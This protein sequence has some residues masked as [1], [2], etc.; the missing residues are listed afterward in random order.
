MKKHI[1]QE[2]QHKKN[3]HAVQTE[4]SEQDGEFLEYEGDLWYE[5]PGYEEIGP[6]FMSIVSSDDLWMYISS[7]GGLTA[8][9]KNADSSLFPYYT[10]DK[11]GENYTNTGPQTIFRIKQEI[12]E[13]ARVAANGNSL[14]AETETGSNAAVNQDEETI[15]WKPFALFYESEAVISRRIRKNVTGNKIMFSEKHSA[16]G[17]EFSYMWTSS[18]AWGWV[19]KAKLRNT[20]GNSFRVDILDGLRNILPSCINSDMQNRMSNLINAYKL[21]ELF[22][23]GIAGFG[24]S[25]RISDKAEAS[26]CLKVTTAWQFGLEAQGYLLS[27]EQVPLFEQGGD[28]ASENRA[29]GKRGAFYVKA[30][31]EIPKEQEVSWMMVL[32]VEQD[33]KSVVTLQKY[34]AHRKSE[35][36]ML[37]EKDIAEA[38]LELMK[39]VGA[40]DGLER[41]GDRMANVHHY[42]NTLFNVMR[43]GVF[44][45]GYMIQTED[46]LDYLYEQNKAEYRKLRM[47]LSSLPKRLSWKELETYLLHENTS[48]KSELS[49]I[50]QSYLPLAFSRRHGDPSRPWNKFS[51]KLRNNDGR[52]RYIYEGNWR[53][54]FQNWE[55]LAY[56]FP[57]YTANM[58][59]VCANGITIDGYNP[60]RV[61]R[62]GFEWEKPDPDDP[63]SNIGYWGDHQIIYLLKL[64]ESVY[65]TNPDTFLD[66][67]TDQRFTFIDVPYKIKSFDK[68]LENPYET[69]IFDEAKDALLE[70]RKEELGYDGLLLTEHDG[71]IYTVTLMEKL[72]LIL[73]VKTTNFIPG[74]GIWMNTQRPEWNDANNALT[75]RGL[76]MVT[77]YYMIREIQFLKN[78]IEQLL[79][80]ERQDTTEIHVDASLFSLFIEIMEILEDFQWALK[81]EFTQS[82]RWDFL[83]R[84]GKAGSKYRERAY[85]EVSRKERRVLSFSEIK[86]YL[87]DLAEYLKKSG[88]QGR[89]AD[90]MF[91]AYTILSY[92]QKNGTAD[93]KPLQ[94][95]LEGQVAILS[96]GLLSA[97]ETVELL[98]TLKE[99]PLYRKDQHS[100]I[101]YPRTQVKG[102]LERNC[103]PKE[104]LHDTSIIHK[105][106]DNGDNS[107]FTKDAAGNYHFASKIM[108]TGS[109]A[110]ILEKM[111]NSPHVADLS[112]EEKD[113]VF[114]VF[115]EVFQHTAFTGRSG[116]MFA[117][118]GVGS[119]YW[120]M[121]SK[122][123]LAV[124][125]N[126]IKAYREGASPK[127]VSLLADAYYDIQY[128]LGYRKSA[129]KYGAFPMD[130]YS[131]T[132][133]RGGARQP[134]MTGQVKEEV[135]TRMGEKGL[136]FKDGCIVIDP[137]FMQKSE[138]VQESAVFTYFDVHQRK[139]EV[140]LNKGDFAYTCCQTLIVY[141]FTQSDQ[142]SLNIFY[143][144]GET[145]SAEYAADDPIILSP[146]DSEHVRWRDGLIKGIEITAAEKMVIFDRYELS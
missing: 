39:I 26:E 65:A 11:I 79:H 102:F 89:R 128:G 98:Q 7:T 36:A 73:L 142:K 68:I 61:V 108:N 32:E 110:D 97:E 146:E 138:L 19:R 24:M 49:R 112:A 22:P 15:I 107:L 74:G 132:V 82:A 72:L 48:V 140:R 81:D 75:G 59:T 60:Y 12:G 21:N 103:I 124:Q 4:I 90:G 47:R 134:G 83:N 46:F 117:Y 96:S 80:R 56:S 25:T 9:R 17:L 44:I 77:L 88:L 37:V 58:L 145:Y 52:M 35:T 121:V 64:M 63:W 40:A 135:L 85:A 127:T 122:L 69:I 13:D 93:I 28:L 10:H 87:F 95:M 38:E 20:G 3:V 14:S 106:I 27:E 131:H 92:N 78:I 8:G 30:S 29:E 54:I 126:L 136:S 51:I 70:K 76:S 1:Q 113:F 139:Q 143:A 91:H 116:R 133:W 55:P 57:Q 119:I 84:M 137:F 33:H 67:L 111:E 18:P 94:V 43:G 129:G 105:L 125:E 45:D 5:I 109:V 50:M 100:Y 118:E 115:E 23:A 66:M 42:S 31:L 71:S 41:T 62:N 99:S 34:L 16:L 6:F 130:P 53:D 2:T 144:D 123:L 104:K 120:H 141:H 114:Q 101:L 86:R